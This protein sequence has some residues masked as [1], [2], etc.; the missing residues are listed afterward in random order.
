MQDEEEDQ[1]EPDDKGVPKNYQ[2]SGTMETVVL[3]ETLSK[4][5]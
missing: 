4:I 5:G 3:E 2:D 1:E